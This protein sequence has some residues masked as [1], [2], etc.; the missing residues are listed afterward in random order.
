M[1]TV[2]I[3][4]AAGYVGSV[5]VRHLLQ[6]DYRILAYDRFFFGREVFDDL[7]ADSRLSLVQKDIRD[8]EPA[9]LDG[10]DMVCDLAALS[11]D[12]SGEIDSSLT[13]AINHKGRQRVC[14]MAKKAGV[15]Q[16]VLAS[17][18]SAYGAGGAL[19]LTEESPTSPLTAY[20]DST[21]KAE[22]DAF[23]LS[24]RTFAVTVLRNATVF[25]LSPRM[26][27]DLVINLM[28]LH[29]VEKGLITVMGG[30]R[31]WRPLVHVS[32][33]A[34]AFRAVIE[35]PKDA[36]NGQVFNVGL[37]NLQ[38]R[39]MAFIVRETVPIPVTIS[40]APDDAD[41]RDY[42]VS[43]GKAKRVLGFAAQTT[44]EDGVREVYDAL[45]Y[46][47]VDFTPKMITV[48]WYRSILDAK[49]LIE[50]IEL[51]GRIL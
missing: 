51:N 14:A 23:K 48:N 5:L 26:R 20:A 25:G 4:G 11:N 35:A 47:R 28:T 33:V 6:S 15:G 24:D 13:Y 45:K 49:A 19:E 12:P 34:R 1:E 39:S 37:T 41:R 22:S 21:L 16:Y 27:F 3:T 50:R 36:V 40:I 18:C 42:N 9:D 32:D 46:G 8:I 2:L 30:G 43:F 44:V 7:R 10:V 31:Q 38:V 29:A 17:S